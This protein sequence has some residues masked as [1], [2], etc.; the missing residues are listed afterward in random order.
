MLY[1]ILVL[2]IGGQTRLSVW[3]LADCFCICNL[4]V[5]FFRV[6]VAHLVL[7]QLRCWC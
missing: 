6:V 1:L 4:T 2:K 5:M 7:Q 3:V